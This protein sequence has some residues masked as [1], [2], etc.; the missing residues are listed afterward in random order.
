MDIDSVLWGKTAES[1]RLLTEKELLNQEYMSTNF[2]Y[3]RTS[4]WRFLN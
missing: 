2:K 1:I 4:L 3:L